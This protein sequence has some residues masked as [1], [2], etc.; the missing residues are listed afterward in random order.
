MDSLFS[1]SIAV[2]ALVIGLSGPVLALERSDVISLHPPLSADNLDVLVKYR[3]DNI[4]WC[5]VKDPK[6]PAMQAMGIGIHMTLSAGVWGGKA[7]EVPSSFGGQKVCEDF[8]GKRVKAT[9]SGFPGDTLWRMCANKPGWQKQWLTEKIKDGMKGF[10]IDE[11]IGSGGNLGPH[12]RDAICYCDS[13]TEKFRDYLRNKYTQEELTG[14]GVDDLDTY[15]HRETVK[16]LVGNVSSFGW[17]WNQNTILFGRDYTLF[18]M[19]S[20]VRYG[21]ELATLIRANAPEPVVITANAWDLAPYNLY[22]A[23]FVDYFLAE[24]HYHAGE[25]TNKTMSR[26]LVRVL[27]IADAVGKPYVACPSIDDH[28]K[29][30]AGGYKNENEIKLWICGTYALGG[31]HTAPVVYR[32][33][34][35]PFHKGDPDT[36]G[37]I[38]QFIKD[39]AH[40]LDGYE[41]FNEGIALIYDNHAYMPSFGK[42]HLG[43]EPYRTQF[44]DICAL[45]WDENIQ[46]A[47]A[48]AGDPYFYRERLEDRELSTFRK[49]IV[50]SESYLQGSQ[51]SLVDD[52]TRTG[53]AHL[54]KDTTEVDELLS[55]YL[56]AVSVNSPAVWANVR[57]HPETSNLTIHLL[58]R[59]HNPDTD[60][61]T[62]QENIELTVRNDLLR[63]PEP[64]KITVHAPGK[65]P[66]KLEYGATEEAIKISV[67]ELVMWSIVE[68]YM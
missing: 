48:V 68:I 27:K 55:E 11:P 6:I 52:L 17:K 32:W 5:S 29:L 59:A 20:G 63:G 67:D 42:M 25:W 60:R 43:S 47:L 61:I 65:E 13:C 10:H 15:N 16:K 56:P 1:F 12:F 46:F 51:K 66:K 53:K 57:R 7:L 40:L 18:Q 64:Y 38:Y 39:N 50:P 33:A 8:T 62:V 45:L 26:S 9:G 22:T 41:S 14:L 54:V 4:G 36:F 3:V 23:E 37:P 28:E 24:T 44:D 34:G 31:H 21:R 30:K 35:T 2:L 19:L 58:N 49:V